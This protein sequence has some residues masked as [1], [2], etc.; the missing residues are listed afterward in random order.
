MFWMFYWEV[1]IRFCAKSIV[2]TYVSAEMKRQNSFTL[3]CMNLSFRFLLVLLKGS[4]SC[5]SQLYL[6][7]TEGVFK[8]QRYY[9][10][11]QSL[12]NE[13]FS[14]LSLENEE[15]EKGNTSISMGNSLKCFTVN[16]L[17]RVMN[18]IIYTPV[19]K[20]VWTC[21][22]KIGITFKV[23]ASRSILNV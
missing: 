3:I 19:S 22:Q 2:F 11:I 23:S 9:N 12:R 5:K 15:N 7:L 1:Q 14:Q 16:K 20:S 6:C 8:K 10:H 13:N 18:K 4:L 21:K 17:Y